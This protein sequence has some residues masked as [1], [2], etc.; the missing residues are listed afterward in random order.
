MRNRLGR[1]IAVCLSALAL[2][3]SAA[4]VP[5]PQA[6]AASNNEIAYRYFVAKGLQPHQSAGIIGNLIQESGSP[7]NPRANQPNGPGMGIAQWSEGDRWATLVSYARASGRDPYSLNLQLDF[8]WHELS[9]VSGYGLASLKASTNVTSATQVFM[10]KFERCGRCES[11]AR[12][13]F[14]QQALNA[15]GGGPGP[16]PVTE[17]AKPVLRQGSRGTAVRTAQYVLRSK[18]YNIAAD[19]VFGAGT[20]KAVTAFQGSRGLKRDGIVGANTWSALLPTLSQGSRGEDVKGLQRELNDEGYR[21]TV[22]G[23]FGTGTKNAVIAYQTRVGLA[24]DGVVGPMTW[25]SLID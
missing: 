22:D 16:G 7:I 14:A 11:A 4:A 23:V 18:G 5:A 17:T 12:V 24:Q 10:T 15:Y 8:V 2:T 21:L 20:N 25:G 1:W 13:R 3:V 6:S 19:G 9:T